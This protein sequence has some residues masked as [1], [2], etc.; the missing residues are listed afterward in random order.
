MTPDMTPRRPSFEALVVQ[1]SVDV[2]T[3]G[4]GAQVSVP[5]RLS[6]GRQGVGPS[7]ALTWT[8]GGH[9]PFGRGW[10]LAGPGRIELDTARGVPRYRGDD[11]VMFGGTRLVPALDGEAPIVLANP[12]GSPAPDTTIE[13]WRGQGGAHPERFERWTV[14]GRVHWLRRRRDAV[15][16]VYG[17][18]ADDSS[19][20]VDPDDPKRV[21]AWLLEAE[22]H[23]RGDV[24]RYLWRK[25]D[26]AAV[27]R[28]AMPE[29]R[30][31]HP[32]AQ[33]Y[34][35]RIQYGNS[36][37]A[38]LGD[39][40]NA[41][42]WRFEVVFDYGD[43]AQH[44]PT[45][46]GDWPVRPDVSTSHRT[47]FEVRTRRRCQRVLMC[48]HFDEI[49]PDP[50]VVLAI[51]LTHDDAGR[52]TA[53]TERGY[54]HDAGGVSEKAR[55]PLSLT[56]EDATWGDDF[57]GVSDDIAACDAARGS[58][59]DLYGEGLPG[60]LTQ[61]GSIWRF[62][63]NL[64]AGRYGPP[65]ILHGMPRA[66]AEGHLADLDGDGSVEWVRFGGATAGMQRFDRREGRWHPPRQ[67]KR[68]PRVNAADGG[69]QFVDLTGDGRPDLVVDRGREGLLYFPFLGPEGFGD[70]IRVERRNRRSGGLPTLDARQP[71]I[72]LADMTGDGLTD[73]VEIRGGRVEYWPNLGHGR[74]GAGVVMADPPRLA[75]SHEKAR[76]RLVD[77][78]G[79]GA[80]GL[81]YIGDGELRYWPN[82]GGDRFGAPRAVKKTP[83]F[84]RPEELKIVDLGDGV[85][86][87]AWHDPTSTRALRALTLNDGGRPGMLSTVDNGVGLTHRLTWRWSGEDL[88]RDRGTG[89]GWTTRL[90]RH[91]PVVASLEA[92]DGIGG[93]RRITRYDWHDGEF[94]EDERTA[95]GF[96]RVDVWEGDPVGATHD[97]PGLL[98]RL[99]QSTAKSRRIV[100]RRR[101]RV[102]SCSTTTP[103][104]PARSGVTR[105]SRWRLSPPRDMSISRVRGSP[106]SALSSA[107]RIRPL[108]TTSANGRPTGA[109]SASSR[110]R[111]ALLTT[112]MR[113]CPSTATTAS[114]MPSSTA[115]ERSRSRASVP[116]TSS[117]AS[118]SRRSER[119][120]PAISS[121]LPGPSGS[122]CP[123]A[124]ARAR[125]SSA[126]SRRLSRSEAKRLMIVATIKP[127][128]LPTMTRKRMRPTVS[129]AAESGVATRRTPRAS[130]WVNGTAT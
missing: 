65:S 119:S 124:M 84:V 85:S 61:S 108:C 26:F 75:R 100:S 120:R 110:A 77:L 99:W 51:E 118:S 69:V 125:S 28:R 22:F 45:P 72:Y 32:G 130:G 74:F 50:V 64:G 35:D 12:L 57:V 39:D 38:S 60:L 121:P 68:R 101:R 129:S 112:V 91:R 2:D 8:G 70:P 54:R 58:W 6:R 17:E 90:P 123:S 114:S 37:P 89:R 15:I 104:A 23:P 122:A 113:C 126:R 81:L 41:I 31:D 29:M 30:R 11:R 87:M 53:I 14:G 109:L 46:L 79:A 117:R 88:L 49:D 20:I 67:F 16:E 13:R 105:T 82:V 71:H 107:A 1:H 63:R 76:V 128:A 97:T 5:L 19:R 33:R 52:I 56:Y 55:P 40:L 48:H 92:I 7:L 103:P 93:D 25:E 127:R 3:V 44:T 42:T 78:D 83:R 86:R 36:A 66:S 115:S 73:V 96:A 111:P 116:T 24:V 34:P 106:A 59:V 21:A 47:G 10:R 94:D 27:D 43:L 80:A 102:T 98:T 4:G 18:A 62:R 9:S 95:A